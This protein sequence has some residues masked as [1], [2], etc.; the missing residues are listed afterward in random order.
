MMSADILPM[1]PPR[2]DCRLGGRHRTWAIHY[3]GDSET[4]I[5]H[6]PSIITLATRKP[7]SD[8][9]EFSVVRKTQCHC[10]NLIFRRAGGRFAIV[11]SAV[12][13]KDLAC[14]QLHQ[15]RGRHMRIT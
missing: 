1:E 10:L 12:T 7:L 4:V 5:G 11:F 9:T 2:S 13:Q 14:H 8:M 3:F 15:A 6:G